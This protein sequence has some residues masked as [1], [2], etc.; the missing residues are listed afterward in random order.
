M[1][2]EWASPPVAEHRLTMPVPAPD[3]SV[4]D[5][6]DVSCFEVWARTRVEGRRPL[7]VTNGEELVTVTGTASP[8][9]KGLAV[10]THCSH[11]NIT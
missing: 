1:A 3:Q 10:K 5:G 6:L 9:V 4:A 7:N 2:P 11:A 8:A